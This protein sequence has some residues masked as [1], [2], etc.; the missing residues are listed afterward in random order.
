MSFPPVLDHSK[1]RNA[2]SDTHFPGGSI[3][4]RKSLA[5]R[6]LHHQPSAA[7]VNELRL[8]TGGNF[9]LLNE[10]AQIKAAGEKAPVAAPA[11]APPRRQPALYNSVWGAK[12]TMPTFNVWDYCKKHGH[13]PLPTDYNSQAA[14]HMGGKSMP[15]PPINDMKAW[16]AEYGRPKIERD[17]PGF[18]T[19]FA[20]RTNTVRKPGATDV[21][22]TVRMLPGRVLK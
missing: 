14:G 6:P 19:E 4:W 17:P 8:A 11:G 3:T 13:A 5:P 15:Q 16:F 22:Q 12:S 7:T 2:T 9:A 1:W 20:A 21:T 18:R 10:T